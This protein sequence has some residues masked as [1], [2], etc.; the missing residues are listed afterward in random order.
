MDNNN[1]NKDDEKKYDNNNK[2]KINSRDGIREIHQRGLKDE[3]KIV[4]V[5]VRHLHFRKKVYYRT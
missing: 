5:S 3:R 2:K 4:G 1:N